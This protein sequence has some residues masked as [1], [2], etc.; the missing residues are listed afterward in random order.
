MQAAEASGP[1]L[2]GGPRVSP[3][4][5]PPST[6]PSGTAPEHTIPRRRGTPDLSRAL[7]AS[8]FLT[9]RPLSEGDLV[10]AER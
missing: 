9:G 10:A 2:E 7:A 8:C 5:T 3:G 1:A 6:Y 4:H